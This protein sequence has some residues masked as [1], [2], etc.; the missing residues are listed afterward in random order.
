MYTWPADTKPFLDI[1]PCDS[2]DR[3]LGSNLAPALTG[4]GTR[5]SQREGSPGHTV[6]DGGD[7]TQ[8]L[9]ARGP[10]HISAVG[11]LGPHFEELCPPSFWLQS[12]GLTQRPANYEA[13][14]QIPCVFVWST[15]LRMVIAS[16]NG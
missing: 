9:R 8:G 2:Q 14:C 1:I 10:S 7:L 15:K 4:Q 3:D 12:A 11:A 13:T 5:V 16:L 6:G